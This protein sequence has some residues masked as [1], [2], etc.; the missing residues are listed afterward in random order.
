MT[1]I[2][3]ANQKNGYDKEQVDSY[4]NKLTEAYQK[5]YDEYLATS[6]KY[7][8]LLEDYKKL[9]AEKQIDVNSNDISKVLMD[10]EKLAQEIVAIANKIVS[11][12][13]I[14]ESRILANAKK[15]YDQANDKIEQAMN[16]AQKYL[17]FQNI[18][19][20]G[21]VLNEMQVAT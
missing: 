21:G 2:L 17:T 5:V 16:E 20:L 19:D 7:S 8:A 1:E 14:E 4:I 15:N 10:S 18:K 13:Y 12:A 9:E 11:N 3:F 6:E